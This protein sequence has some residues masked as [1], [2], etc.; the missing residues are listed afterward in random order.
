MG[1]A[2]ILSHLG[3]SEYSVTYHYDMSVINN[4]L[5]QVNADITSTEASI[6]STEASITAKQIET[7]N[8]GTILDSKITFYQLCIDANP[9]EIEICDPQ[10]IAMQEINIEYLV[11]LSELGDL[12]VKLDNFKITL[13]RLKKEKR[14]LDDI[15]GTE[16]MDIWCIDLCD[17]DA[18]E[19]DFGLWLNHGEVIPDSSIVGT[20]DI[21]DFI[22]KKYRIFIVPASYASNP[23]Y[24][25]DFH[26]IAGSTL[27]ND[28]NGFVFNYNMRGPKEAWHP[29]FRLAIVNSIENGIAQITYNNIK[30]LDGIHYN[31]IDDLNDSDIISDYMVCS[32]NPPFKEGDQVIVTFTGDK[33][34]GPTIIGYSK[35]PKPCE[36]ELTFH[37]CPVY[38]KLGSGWSDPFYDINPP[39]DPIDEPYGTPLGSL[40]VATHDD[41]NKLTYLRKSGHVPQFAEQQIPFPGNNYWVGERGTV[42]WWGASASM[43]ISNIGT[44]NLSCF[45]AVIGDFVRVFRDSGG[46]AYL[47]LTYNKDGTGYDPAV[48]DTRL[49]NFDAYFGYQ[50]VFW[51][52][53][54]Y[55]NGEEKTLTHGTAGATNG[56]FIGGCSII[57]HP[58]TGHWLIYTTSPVGTGGSLVAEEVHAVR[59]FNDAYILLGTYEVLYGVADSDYN[60]GKVFFSDN[61]LKFITRR[62]NSHFTNDP[63]EEDYADD[64]MDLVRGE[65]TFNVLGIPSMTTSTESLGGLDDF[66]RKN[67]RET[68]IGFKGNDE[69]ITTMNPGGGFDP[70]W[71]EAVFFDAQH[72][73]FVGRMVD[74]VAG[75]SSGWSY[76]YLFV[77][78]GGSL[79]KYTY[80]QTD[81]VY[82]IFS[83]AS[84]GTDV[85]SIICEYVLDSPS[86]GSYLATEHGV[87]IS[88]SAQ[89]HHEY[90]FSTEA[91][92]NYHYSNNVFIDNDGI[93]TDL[94]ELCLKE[95][96]GDPSVSP[97]P[98]L[99]MRPLSISR[100]STN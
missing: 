35:N 27:S 83:Q 57:F 60:K 47:I 42:G 91:D 44:A 55:I 3:H 7:D 20:I 89:D 16:N 25:I 52:H 67:W 76:T 87:F 85:S 72:D 64:T 93:V 49:S 6:T 54:V 24:D 21:F 40:A 94:S 68:I 98:L 15:D 43:A 34:E 58:T 65:I 9:I 12:E 75:S 96:N 31:T 95:P 62:A 5:I 63:T 41:R 48:P 39:N 88:L 4:K 99:R 53:K 79:Y 90:P 45:R 66:E 73:I 77:Q 46:W 28:G 70:P 30:D 10:K 81:G 100:K 84:I 8:L 86:M 22:T 37:Y 97:D 56:M 18:A 11:L 59:L 61:G 2:T 74:V 1:K 80:N 92:T 82:D 29:E 17:R 13:E 69:S 23:A 26:G 51:K 32:S 19:P 71:L 36:S 33:M 50:E 78:V 14:R 38:N